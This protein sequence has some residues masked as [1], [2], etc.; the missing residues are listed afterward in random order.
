MDR[1]DVRI[2]DTLQRDG[3]LTK[4]ELAERVGSSPSTCLRRVQSL[5][6]SGHL[7]RCVYLA[8]PEKLRRGLKAIITVV[9]KDHGRKQRYDFAQR[10]RGEAAIAF[11]YGTTGEVDAVLFGNF[12]GMEEYQSV[13][14]RLFDHD[15]HIV[16]YTTFFAVESYKQTTEVP[17]D[18]LA[19]A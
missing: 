3:S 8:N 15:P 12:S 18:M 17:T 13:C 10:A 7:D 9:T 16:R 2:L 14:D 6:K 1:L 11:A 4:A 19:E 5:R